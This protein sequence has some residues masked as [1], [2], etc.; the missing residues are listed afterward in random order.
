MD[1]STYIPHVGRVKEATGDV[2]GIEFLN[3]DIL[4]G[5][6]LKE[7]EIDIFL[8]VRLLP[9]QHCHNILWASCG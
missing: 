5:P 3:V 9:K 2:R 8:F 1:L 7:N 6:L 4:R